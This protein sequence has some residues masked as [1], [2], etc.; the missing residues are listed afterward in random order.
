MLQKNIFD[1]SF[2]HITIIFILI[3]IHSDLVFS[4]YSIDHFRQPT[5]KVAVVVVSVERGAELQ[6]EEA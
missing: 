1:S 6:T 4:A 2:A 3:H 5:S